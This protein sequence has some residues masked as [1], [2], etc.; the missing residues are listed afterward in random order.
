M[1][2]KNSCV[3]F[4]A[5]FDKM[6]HLFSLKIEALRS[7][8]FDVQNTQRITKYSAR[9]INDNLDRIELKLRYL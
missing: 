1:S 4:D 3:N 7:E 6:A 9:A 5:F 2:Y 8:S